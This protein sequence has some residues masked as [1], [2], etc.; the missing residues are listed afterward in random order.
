MAIA[1]VG[2]ALPVR[3]PYWA[4]AGFAAAG[5]G[6]SSIIPLVFAAGGRIAQVSE[7]AGVAT[8]RGL[9][10]I[11]FLVG[12]PAIG[13]LAEMTSL[14]A[15]LFRLV[16]LSLTSSGLVSRVVR[17]GGKSNPFAGTAS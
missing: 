8:V 12:P 10:Y 4:L 7:G 14:L 9:G 17:G 1:G 6:F 5:A 11:G 13:F 15:G 3:S 16:L 2:F